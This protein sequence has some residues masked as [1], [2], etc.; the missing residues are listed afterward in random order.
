MKPWTMENDLL[1]SHPESIEP[2][3]IRHSGLDPESSGAPLDSGF[4]RNDGALLA[5]CE[6]IVIGS[7]EGVTRI[8]LEQATACAGCGSRG[9]CA[10]SSASAKPQFVDVRLSGTVV[11]GAHVTL[12]LPETSVALA[13]VVGYL[14]PAL[15]LLIGAVIAA[16]L[17]A[18]DLPA[19]WG[20]LLGLVAGLIAVRLAS[21]RFS[22]SLM[23]PSV[24]PSIPISGDP[25]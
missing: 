24:C 25:S 2:T 8:R 19:V 6:G 18:G 10:S 16:G 23:T 17:F 4:R 20:A 21:N 12:S 14:L 15:G 9:T 13:A 5:E 1:A 11:P 22:G 7:R 3:R